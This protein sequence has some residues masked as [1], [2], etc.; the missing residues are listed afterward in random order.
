MKDFKYFIERAEKDLNNRLG[1]SK[2]DF[3]SI[4]NQLERE[5]DLEIR[6][7]MKEEGFDV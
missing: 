5:N 1:F 6:Q 7:I 4:I 3:N 2:D